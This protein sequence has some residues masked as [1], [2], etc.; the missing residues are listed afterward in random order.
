MA[1]KVAENPASLCSSPYLDVNSKEGGESECYIVSAENSHLHNRKV[2]KH[3]NNGT[4][5]EL[6]TVTILVFQSDSKQ[7][8]VSS[9]LSKT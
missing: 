7:K 3:Y 6:P 2:N 5:E 9:F 1:C 4:S 8:S